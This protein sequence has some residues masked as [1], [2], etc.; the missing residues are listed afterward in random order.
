MYFKQNTKKYQL[1]YINIANNHVEN[2]FISS[3][4]FNNKKDIVWYNIVCFSLILLYK[5]FYIRRLSI[6]N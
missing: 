5:L 2:L 6:V 1:T 3:E 4:G